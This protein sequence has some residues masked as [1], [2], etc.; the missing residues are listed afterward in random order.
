MRV[1]LVEDNAACA[2]YVVKMLQRNGYEAWSVETGEAALKQH[3]QADLILVDLGLPDLDG[4]Q[5]CAEIRGMSDTPIIAFTERRTELERVLAF[6]A[7]C[8]D[9]LDKPYGIQELMARV[10]AVLRRARPTPL[11]R[12]IVRG[13]LQIDVAVREARLGAE[14]LS[15]TRKE[16]DLLH[17]LASRPDCVFSR[18]ELMERVW[19][20]GSAAAGRTVDTHVNSL[21]HKLGGSSWIVNVRGVGFRLGRG[22]SAGAA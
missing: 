15:L 17:V 10:D 18:K 21:R 1:L 11:T 3:D 20:N 16:F 9:C 2:Q 22:V 7:G 6:Q 12:R 8:D 13:P 19:N 5:V 4:L 14:L